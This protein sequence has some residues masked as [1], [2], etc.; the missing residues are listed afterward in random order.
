MADNKPKTA[1]L[2][3][4]MLNDFVKEG[5]TLVVARYQQGKPLAKRGKMSEERVFGAA[6]SAGAQ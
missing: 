2:V 1:L 5:G 3:I 6:S 4:D